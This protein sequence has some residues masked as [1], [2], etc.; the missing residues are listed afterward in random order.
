MQQILIISEVN[1]MELTDE[2]Q[3]ELF[4]KEKEMYPEEFD[5]LANA[6]KF[7]KPLYYKEKRK[8]IE[9]P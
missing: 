9:I 3:K 6:A 1:I 7:R 8:F 4:L 5:K 2:Q